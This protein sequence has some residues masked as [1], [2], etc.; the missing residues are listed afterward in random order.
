MI[1][2]GP[3]GK[4]YVTIG[5]PC[6]IC[7]LNENTGKIFRM[8]PD[9]SNWEVVADGVR[10]SVGFD[11]HPKTWELWF[12]DNG[13]DGMGDDIP[14]DELNRV[15]HTGQHF[16]F[17]YFGGKSNKLS[18]FKNRTPPMAVSPPEIE[19]QAHTANLGIDF[20][21]RRHVPRRVQKRCICRAAW[22][23][24]SQRTSRLSHNAY[25]I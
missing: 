22:F 21:H 15:T 13:A 1:D 17:P 16:G 6:N 10:N 25:P 7:K 23:M 18:G 20:L 19:F 2:F 11:W 9:G 12:T 3:D 24:E 5:A 4:I 8:D 14:P